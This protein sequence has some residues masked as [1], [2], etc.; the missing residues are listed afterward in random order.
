MFWWVL[1]ILSAVV[2][3]D[4][5]LDIRG[6]VQG[7]GGYFLL[8][9]GGNTNH[10]YG[11]QILWRIQ[12]VNTDTEYGQ[13]DA[14]VDINQW[15]GVLT[16]TTS[17][18]LFWSSGRESMF[19]IDVRKF[20]VRIKPSWGDIFIGR[21]LVRWGEGVVFSPLDFFSTLERSE[22]SFSR[23][24]VDAVRVR[25]SVGEN[26][27]GEALGLLSS[28]WTNSSLAA[29]GGIEVGEWYF[30]GAAFWNTGKNEWKGGISFKGDLG[31][32]WYGEFLSHFSTSTNGN[33]LH[34]MVGCDYSLDRWIL[35]CEYTFNTAMLSNLSLV[36][37]MTHPLYPFFSHHYAMLQ[38]SFLPTV[39]DAFSLVGMWD[40]DYPDTDFQD[41][42]QRYSFS[43]TRNLYQNVVF[44]GWLQYEQGKSLWDED[45]SSLSVFLSVKVMY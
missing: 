42:P 22:G 28:D 8:Q 34:G 29:R 45:F 38:V 18:L 4:G 17:G 32:T 21:Q 23:R 13:F 5:G 20:L 36:E 14:L 15:G 43:Y 31:L 16:N 9:G 27:F 40:F 26:G 10:S 11:S 25:F 39:L 41:K 12:V 2:W 37:K 1:F 24:G 44:S 35:R 3:A 33:F 19:S 6:S 30:T 7:G